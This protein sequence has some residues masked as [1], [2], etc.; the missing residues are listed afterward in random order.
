MEYRVA[1]GA[2]VKGE[3]SLLVLGPAGDPG[4]GEL[5]ELALGPGLGGRGRRVQITQILRTQTLIQSG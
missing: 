1:L 2:V 3:R 5:I 4:L